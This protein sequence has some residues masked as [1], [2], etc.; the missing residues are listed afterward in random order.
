[1]IKVENNSETTDP[2]LFDSLPPKKDVSKG[3]KE[4]KG[5]D[6]A[7]KGKRASKNKLDTYFFQIASGNIIRYFNYGMLLPVKYIGQKNRIT[8]DI[9]TRYEDYL[10]LTKKIC[11]DKRDNQLFIEIVL[12]TDE[13]KNIVKTKIK[14]VFLYKKPVPVSRITRICYYNLKDIKNAQENIKIGGDCSMVGVTD[15]IRDIKEV[16]SSDIGDF[17]DDKNIG[18]YSDKIKD[19]DKIMGMFSFM[20]NTPLY[21]GNC[22][23]YSDNYFKAL[24]LIN[25]NIGEQSQQLNTNEN[26]QTFRRMLRVADEENDLFSQIISLVYDREKD[27]D[28]ETFKD[29]VVE[30]QN[31]FVMEELREE[32]NVIDTARKFMLSESTKEYKK[33]DYSDEIFELCFKIMT[34]RMIDKSEDLTKLYNDE[35]KTI[36]KLL[37]G[38]CATA[39]LKKQERLEP[40][41]SNPKLLHYYYAAYLGEYGDRFGNAAINLKNDISDDL[42]E[43]YAEITLA[44]MGLYFGYF[45]LPARET[46]DNIYPEYDKIIENPVHIKFKLDSRLDLL[47]IESIYQFVFHEKD[48]HDLEFIIWPDTE[49]NTPLPD[50][51]VFEN[52]KDF[53]FKTYDYSDKKYYSIKKKVN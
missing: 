33:S 16:S 37:K 53:E 42:P 38:D 5:N 22:A 35:T 18:K 50:L 1:L 25:L 26:V 9:Q 7:K 46:I 14:N 20:K 31:K 27:F 49:I 48:I 12:S 41:K 23:N 3:N 39:S 17:N 2:T 10:V 28:L 21:Y 36:Q 32:K 4:Q 47:T 45:H 30:F 15:K 13:I 40:L 52:N 11:I 51:S 19:F 29:L 8:E 6:K 34:T 43:K 44:L 24:N